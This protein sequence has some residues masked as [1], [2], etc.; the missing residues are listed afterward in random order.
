MREPERERTYVCIDLKSYYASVEC[1]ARGLDP[2]AARLLVADETRSDNTI[3]LAVSPALKA[4][5]VRSRPRLFEAKQ[6]VKLAEARL[7]QRIDFI[8]AP[9]RMAEYERVS[10]AIYAIYLKYVAVEDIHVYS[11]DEVF[12]DVT[13]YLS[14]YRAAAARAGV[15]PA[16]FMAAT[17][18]RDVLKAT[19]ITATVGIGNNLYLA[20]VAMDIVAKKAPPDEDGV[21]IAALDEALYKRLLWPVRPLT[22]FWQMGEGKTRR[23]ARYGILTMGDIARTSIADEE[24]LYR[25]FGIDA[26]ILIDHAWG[27]EPCTL[28]DIKAYRPKAR[29]LSVGQVLPR[30]YAF[31]EAKLAFAEMAEQLS[32]DLVSKGL[33]TDCASFWVAFDPVSLEKC[34]YDGPLAI[35]YYGRL[36]PKHT[37][38]TVRLRT[39]TSS[40]RLLRG[41]LLEAFDARVDRRL[42][43]RRLGVCAGDTHNECLQLDM[44]TDYEALES[45]ERVQR[46]ILEIRRKY[47]NNAILKGMNYLEGATAR[48]RNTQIGG[49]RA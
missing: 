9:P 40:A 35:D 42:Y 12:M 22:A 4:L 45:E 33:T 1:V 23:L 46:T 13:C 3:V 17:I 44:F 31:G 2:L 38:G 11:I 5:G 6:A 43:V 41:A 7:R 30:P 39:R 16:H 49:Q 36:H 10:A 25:L 18:L 28:A 26:E 21:R 27:I 24:F 15:T 14:M 29:S 20:K 48:E 8:I 37:G 47:G 32:M 19:G 34:A